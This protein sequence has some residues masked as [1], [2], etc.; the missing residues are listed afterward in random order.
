M[1]AKTLV[2]LTVA[3]VLGVAATWVGRSIVLANRSEGSS[4][5]AMTRVVVA[6]ADLEPGQL[7]GASDLA[8]AELPEASVS[9]SMFRDSK[10][11]VGRAVVAPVVKGQAMFEGL[12]AP[13]GS[14]GGLSALVPDGM[15]AVSVEVNESSAVAGLLAPGCRVDVIATLRPDDREQISRTIVKNVKVQAVNRRMANTGTMTDEKGPAMRTV[16]L[17]VSPKDAEAIELASNMGRLRLVL[18]GSKDSSPTSSAGVTFAEL[19]G[20]DGIKPAPTTQP[21]EAR[22]APVEENVGPR[23]SVQIIRG[24]SESTV[25]Y[26]KSK[27]G[28]FRS[29]AAPASERP[30]PASSDP[31]EKSK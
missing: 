12:L 15:R 27:D 19:M 1:N 28:E 3:A 30:A 5:P 10:P 23:Q 11:L 26:E 13:A 7:L 9:K 22:P 21:T 31:F 29:V 14:E 25:Y 20:A 6:R 24:S 8:L 18:R 17:I 4:G 2:S 16:T